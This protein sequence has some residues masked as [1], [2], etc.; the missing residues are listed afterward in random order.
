VRHS[1]RLQQRQLTTCPHHPNACL[2]RPPVSGHNQFNSSS[3]AHP[4]LHQKSPQTSPQP[5]TQPQPPNIKPHRK[6]NIFK[7][8]QG[9]YV[10][11][12]KIE[13]VYARSP[14]VLQVRR[15]VCG[16]VWVW[17]GGGGDGVA[18]CVVDGFVGGS[19]VCLLLD[20]MRFIPQA[21]LLPS[22]T[23][24]SYRK[25]PAPTP[26]PTPPTDHT[27]QP[28]CNP[29]SRLCMATPSGRSWWRW[30]C[31]TPSICC[32]GRKTGGALEG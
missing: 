2:Y 26:T 8:A 15:C 7:L 1:L 30:W 32:H 23:P 4:P 16:C 3:R 31:Q 17:V 19:G 20:G 5:Q 21:A 14:F 18:G 6:K 27:A 28:H 22:V 25:P 11:P 29:T 12:E 9:E 13:N 10:A 24:R